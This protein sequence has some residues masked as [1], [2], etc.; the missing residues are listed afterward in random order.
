MV[1]E[2]EVEGRVE[3]LVGAMAVGAMGEE[4]AEEEAAFEE[5][6]EKEVCL[7]ADVGVVV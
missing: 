4:R 5:A 3:D 1:A 6:E 7:E 2:M